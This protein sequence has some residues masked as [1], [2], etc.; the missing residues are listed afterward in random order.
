MS[1]VI[2]SKDSCPFCVKAKK[3]LEQKGIEYTEKKLGVDVTKEDMFIF[4]GRTV[5]TVPQIVLDGKY[6]GGYTELDAYFS[7]QEFEQ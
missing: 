1:A 4:L 7:H 5:K 6:I 2:Y 3:L